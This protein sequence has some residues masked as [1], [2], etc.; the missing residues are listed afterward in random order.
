MFVLVNEDA[1]RRSHFVFVG[2]LCAF[3]LFMVI[4]GTWSTTAK[5]IDRLQGS[6]Q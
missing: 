5:L 4:M 2:M 3:G 6:S 1:N